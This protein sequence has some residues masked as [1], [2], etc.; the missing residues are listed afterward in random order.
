MPSVDQHCKYHN[1]WERDGSGQA[2][3]ILEVYESLKSKQWKK[4][5]VLSKD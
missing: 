3:G 4:D 2:T 1:S 5:A